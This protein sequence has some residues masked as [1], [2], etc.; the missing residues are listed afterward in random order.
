MMYLQRVGHQ[1]SAVVSVLQNSRLV[2]HVNIF[3]CEFPTLSQ[4]RK[5]PR[6]KW[7]RQ[8]IRLNRT[9]EWSND[10]G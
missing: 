1:T 5:E 2:I 4:E 10:E 9:H 6:T 8:V 7:R 3:E